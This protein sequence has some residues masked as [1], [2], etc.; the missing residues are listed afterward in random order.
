MKLQ[1]SKFPKSVH[2]TFLLLAVTALPVLTLTPARAA[3]PPANDNIANAQVITSDSFSINGTEVGA[4]QQDFETSPNF[5]N[6]FGVDLKS[7]VW[8]S[9][10]P[11]VSGTLTF[12]G[13]SVGTADPTAVFLFKGPGTPSQSTFV[14]NS[15]P[16]SNTATAGVTAKQQYFFFV[17]N[18]NYTA[19]PFVLDGTFVASATTPVVTVSVPAPE[20]VRSTGV[21]GKVLVELSPAPTERL[22]VAYTLKGT[23]VNGT[24]Y[25]LLT[26]SVTVPAG[27]TTAVIKIKPKHGAMGMRTVKLIV[28]AGK[29]YTLGSPHQ[30]KVTIVKSAGN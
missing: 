5:P 21:A 16:S 12:E 10:T 24:D 3:S 13:L 14:A 22:Q 7:S 27:K 20:A 28:V 6:T 1:A 30:G 17:A 18:A 25:A 26:E 9:Y 23:A 11:D 15:T 19:H 2:S 29:G 8:Y 4:T